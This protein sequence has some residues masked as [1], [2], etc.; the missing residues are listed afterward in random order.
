MQDGHGLERGNPYPNHYIEKEMIKCLYEDSGRDNTWA[1]NRGER[2]NPNH[3][4][5]K[6]MIK[7]LYEDS[8]RDNT[9]AFK[10]ITLNVSVDIKSST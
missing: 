1:F 10:G 2:R 3:Y 4:I 7:C 5:E 8:G 9:W 6:E